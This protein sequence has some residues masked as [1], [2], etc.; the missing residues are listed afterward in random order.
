VRNNKKKCGKENFGEIGG[1]KK[2][3]VR[4]NLGK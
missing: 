1:R 3:D 2:T 4:D